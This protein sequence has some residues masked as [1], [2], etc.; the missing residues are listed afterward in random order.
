MQYTEEEKNELRK[1]LL[2]SVENNFNSNN[3]ET[4]SE[5]IKKN[6]D[7]LNINVSL[8]KIMTENM[9]MRRK[10]DQM[11]NEIKELKKELIREK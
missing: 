8:Y 6:Y 10:I 9:L 4:E 1:N 2:C 11:D 3:K 5:N 7:I